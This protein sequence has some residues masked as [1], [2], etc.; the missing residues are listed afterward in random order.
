[1]T[2]KLVKVAL[3]VHFA[4]ARKIIMK[5][6]SLISGKDVDETILKSKNLAIEKFLMKVTEL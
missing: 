1:M 5:K 3:S 2:I 4:N 6:K